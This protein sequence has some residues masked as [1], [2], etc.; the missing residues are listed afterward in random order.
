MIAVLNYGMGN[1]SSIKNMLIK[2][3]EHNVKLVDKPDGLM[4]ATFRK[5]GNEGGTG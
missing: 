4:K 5:L 3:G 1:V 2:A